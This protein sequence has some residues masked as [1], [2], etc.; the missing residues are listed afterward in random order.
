MDELGNAAT[1]AGDEGDAEPERLQHGVGRV[2][3][4]GRHDRQ[5]ARLADVGHGL[6]LVAIRLDPRWPRPA[7]GALAE[8]VTSRDTLDRSLAAH[9]ADGEVEA[10]GF[11]REEI[12]RVA[13]HLKA[14][15]GLQPPEEDD[16]LHAARRNVSDGL[17][18]LGGRRSASDGVRDDVAVAEIARRL[19]ARPLGQ[20]PGPREW[21]LASGAADLP[22]T[23][24]LVA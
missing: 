21:G 19:R 13:E 6:Q 2:V 4:R 10:L 1:A 11:V 22:F 20:G 15:P 17:G 14:L 9:E 7:A 24:L 5:P 16:L 8:V 18:G 12:E 23:A 3:D